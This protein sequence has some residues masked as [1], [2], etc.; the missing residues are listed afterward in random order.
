[1]DPPPPAAAGAKGRESA[2]SP[3]RAAPAADGND[4]PSADGSSAPSANRNGAPSP[5]WPAPPRSAAGDAVRPHRTR[6]ACSGYGRH[7][8]RGDAAQ[9]VSVR[10][11]RLRS[12][13][14]ARTAPSREP[15]SGTAGS[16]PN[17]TPRPRQ[18]CE[19]SV[20]LAKIPPLKV[21]PASAPRFRRGSCGS[22][23]KE[24]SDMVKATPQ[25]VFNSGKWPEADSPDQQSLV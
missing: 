5:P 25:H 16:A 7:R 22:A 6:A 21:S 15:R 17:R 20:V 18:R 11:H 1:M 23:R 2:K 19:G 4:A 10:T 8:H 3:D 9:P 12:R 13:G 14:P 24:G